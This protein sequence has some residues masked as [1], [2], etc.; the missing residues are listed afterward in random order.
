MTRQLSGGSTHGFQMHWQPVI[1]VTGGRPRVR[2]TDE[3]KA[4]SEGLSSF[5]ISRV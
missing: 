1:R 2:L 5:N 4:A 3:C